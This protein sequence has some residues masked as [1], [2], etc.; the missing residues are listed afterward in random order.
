MTQPSKLG[1]FCMVLIPALVIAAIII[2]ALFGTG[3]ITTSKSE[4]DN[5]AANSNINLNGNGGLA[6]VTL[7]ILATTVAPSASLCG[8]GYFLQV[9]AVNVGSSVLG[10]PDSCVPCPLGTFSTAAGNTYCFPC[11]EGSFADNVATAFCTVCPVGWTTSP[12]VATATFGAVS[13]AQCN[14]QVTTTSTCK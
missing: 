9:A 7:P 3:T 2:G 6:D 8:A 5:S 11:T 10:S 4:K 14:L 12:L 13:S 1:R